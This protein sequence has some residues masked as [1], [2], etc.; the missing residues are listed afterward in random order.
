[1]VESACRR[2]VARAF[3]TTLA[4]AHAMV[5][6]CMI[7]HLGLSHE[8]SAVPVLLQIAS[9]EHLVLRDIFLRIKAV[10]ALGRMR[11]PEAAPPL[12]RIVRERNG[13]AH[14][15]PAALRSAAEEA[16]ELIEYR[17]ILASWR[18]VEN[19]HAKSSQAHSRPRR[20]L[21][22][23]LRTPLQ[24]TIVGAK[25]GTARVR[26]IALG[27]AFLESDQRWVVG[28]TLHLEIRAGLRKIQSTAVVRNVTTTGTGVEFVHM[29]PN[30]ASG[31]DVWSRNDQV[32]SPKN[33][34]RPPTLCGRPGIKDR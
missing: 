13:L 17:P 27:G 21:R 9:G 18:I 33:V 2:R 20:Y 5:V 12:L 7:D 3:V 32:D 10:E 26:T 15:E 16:L 23:Q 11:T 19:A 14:T 31:C 22:A 4:E 25:G 6:P 1:M 28:D 24:A 34:H 29:K 8:T 30:T